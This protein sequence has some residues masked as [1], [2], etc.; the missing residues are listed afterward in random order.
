MVFYLLS[1][2]LSLSFSVISIKC[3]MFLAQGAKL[4]DRLASGTQLRG[5][6]D[7]WSVPDHGDLSRRSGTGGVAEV[8]KL[9]TKLPCEVKRTFHHVPPPLLNEKGV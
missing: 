3:L 4:G 9:E 1:L 6:E 8:F 5:A 7:T 2:S